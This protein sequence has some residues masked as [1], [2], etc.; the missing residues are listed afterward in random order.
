MQLYLSIVQLNL[1]SVNMLLSFFIVLFDCLYSF[2]VL[3]DVRILEY[4]PTL[5]PLENYWKNNITVRD[6]KEYES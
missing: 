2:A 1:K 4:H 6:V 5:S 3:I